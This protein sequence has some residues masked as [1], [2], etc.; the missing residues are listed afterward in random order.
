[1][2]L[3]LSNAISTVVHLPEAAD[4]SDR[5]QQLMALRHLQLANLT[6]SGQRVSAGVAKAVLRAIDDH[7]AQCWASQETLARE[8]CFDRQSVRRAIAAL[9]SA[10]LLTVT[11]RV[12][13]SS[14]I[15]INWGAVSQSNIPPE[16]PLSVSST[17]GICEIPPPLSVRYGGVSVRSGGS[18]CEIPETILKRE[19]NENR[20]DN[21]TGEASKEDAFILES[22]TSKPNTKPQAVRGRQSKLSSKSK[23]SY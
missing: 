22:Q 9:E 2:E 4:I 14:V 5:G 7:G 15:T 18:I 21:E 12:G 13:A 17:R 19:L 6:A 8:T 16:E 1:M 20:N 11:Q 10:G 3:N 23:L